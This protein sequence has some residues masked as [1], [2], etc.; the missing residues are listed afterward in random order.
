MGPQSWQRLPPP[1]RSRRAQRR[2]S[3]VRKSGIEILERRVLLSVL[4]LN[5]SS[6]SSI[7]PNPVG[8]NI[9]LINTG[10][11]DGPMA[12]VAVT[13]SAGTYGN[14]TT[15]S[16]TVTYEGTSIGAGTVRFILAQGATD[17]YV[18]TGSVGASGIATVDFGKT[19]TAGTYDLTADF[20][21][22]AGFGPQSTTVP[23]AVVINPATPI[24]T[25][26]DLSGTYTGGA[27]VATAL[28]NGSGT[29][30]TVAP[31]LFYASG[32]YSFASQV[33]APGVS[34]TYTAPTEAGH[35]TVLASFAGSTDYTSASAITQ[36]TIGGAPTTVS[37]PTANPGITA[38]GTITAEVSSDFS[39]VTVGSVIFTLFQGGSQVGSPIQASVGSN[40]TATAI[41]GGALPLG[42]FEAEAD[43]IGAND[44][45]A[46]NAAAL[47][48]Y[49]GWPGILTSPGTQYSVTGL[50]GSPILDVSAGTVTLSA[51]LSTWIPNCGLSIENGAHV[52]LQHSQHLA[53]LNIN[54]DGTLDVGVFSAI[55]DYGLL[56]PVSTI[57]ADVISGENHGNWNGPGINSSAAAANPGY[58]VGYGDGADGVVQGLTAGQIEVK[59]TRL[60]DTNLDGVVNGSDFANVAASFGKV[61]KEW[62]QGDFDGNGVVNGSDFADLAANFGKIANTTPSSATSVSVTGGVFTEGQDVTVTATVT[63]G[64]GGQPAIDGENIEF[65]L[66]QPITG[67]VLQSSFTTLPSS[68]VQTCDFG[69]D[70][71]I[72]TYDLKVQYFGAPGYAD[73]TTTDLGAIVILPPAEINIASG[74]VLSNQ[75]AV[76]SASVESDGQPVTAGNVEFRIFQTGTS[77]LL[78]SADASV[79][80]SGVAEYD[81]GILPPGTYD[82][83]TDYSGAGGDSPASASLAGALVVDQVTTVSAQGG[84]FTLGQQDAIATA[85]VLAGGQPITVGG[86][87][88]FTLLSANHN[89]VGS[90][91]TVSVDAD[92]TASADFGDSL[93]PAGYSIMAQYVPVAGYFGAT[94]VTPNGAM[95][96]DETTSLSLTSPTYAAHQDAT[97]DAK[98][99]GISAVRG[100]TVTFTLKESISQNQI[101]TVSGPTTIAVATDGTA[102]ADFGTVLGAGTYIVTAAYSD[103]M[104]YDDATSASG[105]LV[106]QKAFDTTT[107]VTGATFDSNQKTSVTAAVAVA[108]GDPLPSSGTIT[109]LLYRAG[110]TSSFTSDSVKINS[111]GDAT[112]SFGLLSAGDYTVTANF[113]PA[114]VGYLSSSANP[115]A[116]LT[117][118][119]TTSVSLKDAVDTFGQDATVTAT[120]TGGG[121][122]VGA[123]GQVTFTLADAKGNQIESPPAVSVLSDGT[124]TADFGDSIS[125]G[126]YAVT[127]AYTPSA[128]YAAST[129]SAS[130]ALT[131]NDQTSISVTGGAF[132]ENQPAI[133]SA[134]VTTAAGQPLTSG[135][136]T[137][138][139][140]AGGG[141]NQ[142]PIASPQAGT[143]NS[144]GIFQADFGGP[145]NPGDG[146]Y[147]LQATYVGPA[148]YLGSSVI[149]KDAL[150]IEPKVAT[151]VS[152]TT[153]TYYSNQDAIASAAVTA[154]NLP[155][156]AGGVVEFFLFSPKGLLQNPEVQLDTSGGPLTGDASVDFRDLPAL[157]SGTYSVEAEYLG[158]VYYQTNFSTSSLKIVPAATT[159]V[160]ITGGDFFSNQDTLVSTAVMAGGN[161]VTA[162]TV[163]FSIFQTGTLVPTKTSTAVAVDDSGNVSYDFGSLRAGTYDLEADYSGTPGYLPSTSSSTGVV[164]IAK[165]APTTVVVTGGNYAGDQSDVVT[166]AMTVTSGGQAVPAGGTVDFY[167]QESFQGGLPQ[168]I[169]YGSASV[170]STGEAS[171]AFSSE[172]EGS[173]TIQAVYSGSPGYAPSDDIVAHALTID[174]QTP[175]PGTVTSGLASTTTGARMSGEYEETSIN[176]S[177]GVYA[178][179]QDAIVSAAVTAD[180]LPI[181]VGGQVSFLI[182]QTGTSNLVATADVAVDSSGNA[183]YD[184][185][186]GFDDGA[187]DVEADYIGDPGYSD[188]TTTATGALII[189]QPTATS[190][191]VI[192]GNFTS[193]Q[194][195]TVSAAVTTG[196]EP[197]TA[198]GSV[199]FAIF[200]TGSDQIVALGDANIDS[201]GNATYDLNDNLPSGTYDIRAIYSPAPGYAAAVASAAG[202]LVIDDPSITTVNVTG[203][204][205]AGGQAETVSATVMAG[206]QPV[207]SGG[208]IVFTL[209]Q[210]GTGD[211][212]VT[213]T[214]T[215]DS[216]GNATYDFY[217]LQVGT[218]DVQAD[219][220]GAPGY[221]PGSATATGALVINPSTA[222]SVTVTGGADSSGQD[223]IVSAVVTAGNQAANAGAVQFTLFQSG[224]N[225]V[226]AQSADIT[227][228]SAG[229]ASY[230]FGDNLPLGIYDVEADYS[231]A[232]GYSFSTITAASTLTINQSTSVSATGNSYTVGNDATV[233]ATVTGEGQ[234][235]SAGTVQF[236]LFQSGSNVVVAQS[237]AIAVDSSGD[238]SYDFV[239]GLP[240]GT[241]DLEADYSGAPGDGAST[242]TSAG[243]LII[244]QSTSVSVTGGTYF[245][246]EDAT[247]SA[248]ATA[249]GGQVTILLFQSGTN[250]VVASASAT[251]DSSGNASCD[252]GTGL[253]IGSY[254]VMAIYSPTP[255]YAQSS[256]IAAGALVINSSS[257]TSL[258]VTGGTYFNNQDTIVSA[259]VTAGGQAVT[260]GGAVQFTLFQSGTDTVM[261]IADAIVDSSG[262]ASFDFGQSLATGTYDVEAD[263]FGAPGYFAGATT[264]A[265][266][267]VIQ[268][269]IAT[270]VTVTG[271]TYNINQN[272]VIRASA[273]ANGLPVA[274]GGTVEFTLLQ[275]GTNNILAQSPD[276]AVDSSGTATFDFGG[277]LQVG[278]YD[279][280]ADYSG[281]PGYFAATTTTTGALVIDIP[282]A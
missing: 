179:N 19:V 168:T 134:A 38:D 274:A 267:L 222:T 205:Y 247:V 132:A 47:L 137:F 28:V 67:N 207:S 261:A 65:F 219:Y 110:A 226:V 97:V 96:I 126:I 244:N 206:G 235:V 102:V 171:Y 8:V 107:T 169:A 66:M 180:G 76:V 20:S 117:I 94:T 48:T 90:A 228:D 128:G 91:M 120:I 2:S 147:N 272:A 246:N 210:S 268:P 68:A 218:Y 217:D 191:S 17:D 113:S 142:N 175:T 146:T 201:D 223:A 277:S 46:S 276:V 73:N 151:A 84:T 18:L 144:E 31:T 260:A 265:G 40:G 95:A 170:N 152:V 279:V 42:E 165:P 100:G 166:A 173:F 172:P 183:V 160:T 133:V 253:D 194:D 159:S 22:G 153:G 243:A 88:T 224:T 278:T 55:I 200:Q 106:I 82:V 50:P 64:T 35:Y 127:A 225:L 154:S 13:G 164:V 227:V 29:L 231:G 259:A 119:Q 264:A 184:F 116:D 81:F 270:A 174:V 155:L 14:D 30:E 178:D 167:I 204:T 7:P 250:V 282:L 197:L 59:Y 89:A 203:G 149:I 230:D 72:G 85:T 202:A 45:A 103:L 24:V 256:T 193:N 26:S 236:T 187:Y 44:Y 139:L 86:Q 234:P 92:G 269:S 251:V 212:L 190:V 54:G 237:A 232:P 6:S 136:M 39:P 158:N 138:T 221:F 258:N 208:A 121:T 242:T 238:V 263:Y 273:M 233:S 12:V 216:S 104:G 52:V 11:P 23:G 109:F 257:A 123:G 114:G 125:P 220:S 157:S 112:G 199:Q 213:A 130:S 105:S 9:P 248:V 83:A 156:A 75:D 188:I 145:N 115:A 131:I 37:L 98:V 181:T 229:A 255:G 135:S 57:E 5:E 70:L 129:T 33:S 198:G 53:Q 140:F 93:N 41:F 80:S 69:E 87:V 162:G 280:E 275:G 62:D 214:A 176:I 240:A 21:G 196:G 143:L 74:V 63:G 150:L 185:G 16:A 141:T 118:L 254:D 281:V 239:G 182:F 186:T 161:P 177:S 71:A 271:G 266:A 111:S 56:D 195:E 58:A 241:Y 124:A 78:A 61:G 49:S 245:N 189:D 262:N 211:L 3:L 122:P 101:I 249:A 34:G 4:S 60:G 209:T 15:V 27:F 252:F 148:G 215:V 79:A 192:G 108:A 10:D 163:T 32:T 36:L 43:Y 51:D 99:T 77:Q 25:V 1:V